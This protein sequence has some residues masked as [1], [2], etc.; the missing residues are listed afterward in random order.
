MNSPL[1]KASATDTI[2]RIRQLISTAEPKIQ[3]A[4]EDTVR[5]VEDAATL[6]ALALLLEQGRINEALTVADRAI[7]RV[8]EAVTLTFLAAGTDTAQFLEDALKIIIS[9][10]GTNIRA[11]A[12]M[13]NER[14]RLI[15]EFTQEQRRAT[16]TALIEGIRRGENPTA[17]ARRFRQSIGLT[18]QQTQIIDNYRRALETLSSDALTRELRDRRS[19]AAV[20]RAIQLQEPLTQTQIDS[21]VNRYRG[22][23][24]NFRAKTIARTEALRAV[25]QGSREMFRQAIEAGELDIEGLVQIWN[26][27]EDERVRST[28][29]SMNGQEREFDQPFISG[30]GVPLVHPGDPNAPAGEVIRCRCVVS[31]RIRT[32]I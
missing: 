29:T 9:F 31:T 8:A 18:A 5:I 12:Q 25:H 15:N 13:Q 24:I 4:F 23:W 28:H 30:A 16:R 20:R 17:L 26:T 22:R 7:T 27:A 3:R 6:T 32:I 1:I 14:L 2:E 21:L 10:N 19:D 11:V